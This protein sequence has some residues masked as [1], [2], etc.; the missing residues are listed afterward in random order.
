MAADVQPDTDQTLFALHFDPNG[1]EYGGSGDEPFAAIRFSGTTWTVNE[2]PLPGFVRVPSE[3]IA[4]PNV[5]N[6]LATQHLIPSRRFL[7][8][9]NN[10]L[11][12]IERRRPLDQ[13]IAILGRSQGNIDASEELKMF[14]SFVG[15]AEACAM[16]L[17]I[18][19][20]FTDSRAS[21]HRGVTAQ[22]RDWAT[23]AF[24][25]LGS[26]TPERTV[27]Y[28]GAQTQF[29]DRYNGFGLYFMRLLQPVWLLPI[30]RITVYSPD[31]LRLLRDNLSNLLAFAEQ[32]HFASASSSSQK[33]DSSGSLTICV[34]EL[35]TTSSRPT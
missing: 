15:E 19:T 13:L 7:C 23:A 17:V 4:T 14:F 16:C 8:L 6:E 30:N 35:Q 21:F 3:L 27:A 22:I 9:T 29:S 18:A 32:T 31:E 33:Q 25:Y 34:E 26:N 1:K 20:C 12:T 24:L 2:A 5:A 11:Y 10:G 28:F